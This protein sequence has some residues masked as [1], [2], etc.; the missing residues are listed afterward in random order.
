MIKA[1]SRKGVNVEI[2]HHQIVIYKII[3]GF[4]QWRQYVGYSV[5]EAIARFKVPTGFVPEPP[6]N[7]YRVSWPCGQQVVYPQGH[8]G[9]WVDFEKGNQPL[10]HRGVR[11]D[12]MPDDGSPDWAD[13]QRRAKLAPVR[14]S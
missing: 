8:G 1:F 2:H 11:M 9:A 12:I 6:C 3:G 14:L 4:L 5:N 7:L 10:F 13:L